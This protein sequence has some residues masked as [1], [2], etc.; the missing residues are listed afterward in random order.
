MWIGI[1]EQDI[2]FEMMKKELRKMKVVENREEP[3]KKENNTYYVR[4][5]N[6]KS[7]LDN[8]RNYMI[9]RG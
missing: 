1:P 4:H 8:W 9:A 6:K 2:P 7:R 3:F 5:D